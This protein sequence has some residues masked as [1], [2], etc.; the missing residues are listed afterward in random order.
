MYYRMDAQLAPGQ[1]LDWNVKDV[2]YPQK[3]KPEEIG[4]FGWIGSEKE[5][6]YF[7]MR[8]TTRDSSGAQNK[9][10]RLVFR[11]SVDVHTVKWRTAE[12][13]DS[14][15]SHATEW[16]KTGKCSYRRG[17]PI[18]VELTESES[19]KICVEMA[20]WDTSGSRWLKSKVHIRLK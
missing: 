8:S 7:P 10:I 17:Q 3:I 5:K 14:G 1:K 20:A 11:S 9:T 16:K 6:T 4:I 13:I 12:W 19:S 15:C 18:A 2:I